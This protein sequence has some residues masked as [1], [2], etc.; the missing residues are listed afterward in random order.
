MKVLFT[1]VFNLLVVFSMAQNPTYQW[2]TS[3]GGVVTSM[4]ILSNQDVIQVTNESGACQ[5]KKVNQ[6]GQ[7]LWTK[8]FGTESTF[9]NIACDQNDNLYLTGVIYGTSGS[10][11]LDP[12]NN[13]INYT[14]SSNALFVQKLDNEANTIWQRTYENFYFNPSF[15]SLPNIAINN[16][17]GNVALV[18]G[19]IGAL[20]LD[21]STSV[22]SLL[23]PEFFTDPFIGIFNSTGTCLASYSED[24]GGNAAFTCCQFDTNENLIVGGFK[25]SN[26]STITIESFDP[27]LT[28]L[29]TH[30]GTVTAVAGKVRDLKIT[31]NNEIVYCGVEIDNSVVYRIPNPST[32]VI[33]NSIPI[34]KKIY[35]GI[36]YEIKSIAL[37]ENANIYLGG[38]VYG[39]LNVDVS[40]DGL[41]ND[42][43][44]NYNQIRG[45]ITYL[46]SLGNY[47]GKKLFDHNNGPSSLPPYSDIN[48]IVAKG[49]SLYAG[50]EKN[51]LVDFDSDLI[52]NQSDGFNNDPGFLV[53][54][55][56]GNNNL[57]LNQNMNSKNLL[58]LFPN[59]VQNRLFISNEFS[60][61]YEVLDL[62]GKIISSELYSPLGINVGIMTPGIYFLKT[63]TGLYRFV[64]E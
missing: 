25:Y 56:I 52:D 57:S 29:W 14:I 47:L 61:T 64:K 37:D 33:V 13:T 22:G 45:L 62:K 38:G 8:S 16:N 27:S 63:Q 24:I 42:T 39:G 50:G 4:C 41:T 36:N 40:P 23:N 26:G 21:P 15:S 1:I 30:S 43:I 3:Q 49:N 51:N 58:S 18:G 59:P 44:G 17:N 60:G 19:F 32:Q 7:V 46:D 12:G 34:W 48:C 20:N 9:T 5:L 2:M 55:S 54:W 11:D 28:R 6:M 35:E 31:A 53:K 10:C